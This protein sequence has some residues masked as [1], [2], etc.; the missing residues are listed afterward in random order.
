MRVGIVQGAI[1]SQP[2]D[3]V[4]LDEGFKV[5]GSVGQHL[6]G[7]Q[8]QGYV[9]NEKWA[10]ANEAALVS[11]LRAIRNAFSWLHDPKNR[12]SAIDILSAHVK[13]KRDW[14]E[15]VY[16]LMIKQQYLSTDGRPDLKGIENMLALTTKYGTDRVTI[17]RLDRWVN[18]SYMEKAAR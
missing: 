15:Q 8:Y 17:P 7:I 1:V 16:E 11:F 2:E 10:E 5:L 3:L 9:V 12:D 18:M 6:K 4:L 13:V 14:L